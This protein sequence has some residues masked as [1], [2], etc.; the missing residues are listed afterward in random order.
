MDS[1][2]VTRVA[3]SCVLLDFAGAAVL[4]DPWFSER[5]GYFRGE[6][7]GITVANLP[8]LKGVVGSHHHYDHFDMDA[9]REYPDKTVPMA[10]KRGK[11]GLLAR[12]AGFSHVTEL[13]PWESVSLGPVKVT[14]TPA[15]H[16]APQNTYILEAGGFTVFFGG[17]TLLIPELAEVAN[18]FP[19]VDVAL[20]PVN[21][22]SI[23]P[24]LNR[25]VVMT[26]REAAKLCRIL[27]PRVAV[28]I[29]YAYTAGPIRD[30]F[31]L[32]YRGT[33]G[34]FAAEVPRHHP[35][36]TVHILTPGL[37]LVIGS[38]AASR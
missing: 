36:T 32:K 24:L 19:H 17:D 7:L 13:E 37:P 1:L 31:L 12:G 3:H 22:L 16:S 29:H 9:F 33:A 11:C 2:T 34:E 8:R 20:L 21:G 30:R 23:R 15:R 26:A 6:P 27:R 18:R 10:V 5:P 35:A 14:A 25:Q 38:E 28:P 4:T